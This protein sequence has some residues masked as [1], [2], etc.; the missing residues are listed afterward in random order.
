MEEEPLEIDLGNLDD[1]L[2]DLF[3]EEEEVEDNIPGNQIE[4]N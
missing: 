1:D 2:I 3:E 4:K